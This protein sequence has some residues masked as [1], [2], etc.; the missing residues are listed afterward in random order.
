MT[1]TVLSVVSLFASVIVVLGGALGRETL[2]ELKRRVGLL[3][4]RD[5]ARAREVTSLDERSKGQIE[6]LRR[7][8]A[9]MVPRAEWEARHAA[10]DERLDRILS[11]LADRDSA[12]HI[13]LPPPRRTGR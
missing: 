11:L 13:D 5:E 12:A 7:I 1:A 10:T 9:Q 4:T 2:G 3:E 6:A 8:E